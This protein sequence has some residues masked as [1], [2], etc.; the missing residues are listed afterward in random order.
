[1]ENQYIMMEKEKECIMPSS[2]ENRWPKGGG[3]YR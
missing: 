1:M 2:T 3:D